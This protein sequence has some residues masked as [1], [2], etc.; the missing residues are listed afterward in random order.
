MTEVPSGPQGARVVEEVGDPAVLT[1]CLAG[2]IDLATVASARPVFAEALA[3]HP[4]RLVVDLGD[5]T[6]MDSTGIALLLETAQEV[7][8]L[9]VRNPS[10]IL[11]NVIDAMGLAGVLRMTP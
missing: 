5:V 6:F 4:H 3:R 11:R 8:Q 2:D 10:D 9:E 1:V 7:A